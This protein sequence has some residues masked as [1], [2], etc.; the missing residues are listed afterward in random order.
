MPFQFEL[1]KVTPYTTHSYY[2]VKLILD[3]DSTGTAPL[4]WHGIFAGD[5]GCLAIQPVVE[6]NDAGI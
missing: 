2:S 5:L 6:H 4:E 1:N 3:N